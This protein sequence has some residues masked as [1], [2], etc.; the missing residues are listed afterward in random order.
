MKKIYLTKIYKA[1][2]LSRAPRRNVIESYR[3]L[4]AACLLCFFQSVGHI[5]GA[6]VNPAITAATVIL[7]NTSL[8]MAGFYI[9]AQCLGS[10]IGYGLL[11]VNKYVY[12]H[13]L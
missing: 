3:R 7:G 5:S 8:L 1:I 10:M 4:N 9:I 12:I 11:K 13:L 6:H 2:A